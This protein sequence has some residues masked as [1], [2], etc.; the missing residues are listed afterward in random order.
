MIRTT[1]FFI[2]AFS[3]Q[4][5]LAE[6]LCDPHLKSYEVKYD[7]YQNAINLALERNKLLGDIRSW[8]KFMGREVG[9]IQYRKFKVE[10]FLKFSLKHD[11][12]ILVKEHFEAVSNEVQLAYHIIKKNR[13]LS[14]EISFIIERNPN[15]PDLSVLRKTLSDIHAENLK[16]AKTIARRIDEYSATF[17]TLEAIA[18]GTDKSA[19]NARWVLDKLESQYILE[20]FFKDAQIAERETPR[21]KDLFAILDEYA[22]ADIYHL[23]LAKR[24]EMYS[25]LLSISPSESFFRYVDKMIV[26]VPWVNK[27]KFRAFI[28]EVQDSRVHALYYSDIERVL[29]SET[30]A[31]ERL[32]LLI[33]VAS[34]YEKEFLITFSRR[35]DAKDV[36]KQLKEAAAERDPDFLSQMTKAEE[37][38][39]NL[40]RLSILKDNTASKIVTRFVDL[41]F[42]SAITYGTVSYF[43][44]QGIVKSKEDVNSPSKL[45]ENEEKELD[46]YLQLG[47]SVIEEMKREGVK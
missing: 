34:T 5:A 18:K 12:P 14:E 17:N 20:N 3:N 31:S 24:M 6:G 26:K 33:N 25:A 46:E 1:L 36:W 2:L 42:A 23:K 28:A 22:E 29:M 30:V 45:T 21:V 41:V 4:S 19:E 10:S 43:E 9:Q 38:G 35:I 13:K 7:R 37:E 40:S 11:R 8:Q 16:Q 39:R 47:G 27:S 32:D 15:H 44:D